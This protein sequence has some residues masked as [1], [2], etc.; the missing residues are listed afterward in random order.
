MNSIKSGT[1]H[2]MPLIFAL[3]GLTIL[4]FEAKTDKNEQILQ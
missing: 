2:R 1:L 4:S 3:T